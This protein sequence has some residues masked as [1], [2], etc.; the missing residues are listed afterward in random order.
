MEK[1]NQWKELEIRSE[2]K[3]FHRELG[4]IS[5]IRENSFINR[6]ILLWND[7]PVNIKKTETF[8]SIKAGLDGLK[9]F[10]K[11]DKLITKLMLI[12]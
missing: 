2:G 11:K 5:N 7:L 1:T 12:K 3:S 9:L 4:K 10:N 8:D 6:I